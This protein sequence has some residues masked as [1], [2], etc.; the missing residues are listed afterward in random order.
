MIIAT[1]GAGVDGRARARSRRVGQGVDG[2]NPPRS[3]KGI[4][5][6]NEDRVDEEG[7]DEEELT[8]TD[9]YLAR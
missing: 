8:F 6:N 2:W 3:R 7:V 4:C 5:L 9:L 1:S